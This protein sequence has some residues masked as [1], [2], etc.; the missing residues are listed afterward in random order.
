MKGDKVKPKASCVE[1]SP[2]PIPGLTK[3]QYDSFLKHFESGTNTGD[4][5]NKRV[6]N[7]TGRLADEDD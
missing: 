3:E 2:S 6:A 7:M 1:G 5:G 4:E